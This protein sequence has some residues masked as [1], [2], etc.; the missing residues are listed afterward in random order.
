MLRHYVTY[1]GDDWA[2]YLPLIQFAYNNSMHSSTML[3]PFEI[4]QGYAP[5]T[6]VDLELDK[7]TGRS[8]K[9]YVKDVVEC[10]Q[11]AAKHIA[12]A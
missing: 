8:I 11:F 1:K 2:L 7:V 10:W 4:V 9:C 3:T 12:K 6:I 5:R